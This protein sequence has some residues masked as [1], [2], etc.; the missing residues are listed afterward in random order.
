MQEV[1]CV[2]QVVA[3]V[4]ERLAQRVLVA[5]GRDGG[6]LRDQAVRGDFTVLGIIDIQRVVVEGGQR[7]NY[8][9]HDGHRV[10]I[11]AETAIQVIQLFMYHRMV[12][13]GGFELRFLR[14]VRQFTVEQQIADFHEIA[15]LAQVFNAITAVHQDACFSVDIGDFRFA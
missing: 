3:R 1:F 4:H 10:G 9:T 15:F 2:T 11:A 14:L 6:H 13:D 12:G 7:A 8:A 5:H